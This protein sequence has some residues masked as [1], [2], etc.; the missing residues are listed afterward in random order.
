MRR[1]GEASLGNAGQSGSGV[2]KTSRMV[3]VAIALGVACAFYVGLVLLPR[4]SSVSAPQKVCS[5]WDPICKADAHQGVIAWLALLI[6][7]AAGWL[8][9]LS[10]RADRRAQEAEAAATAEAER[11]RQEANEA[12]ARRRQAAQEAEAEHYRALLGEMLYEDVH[13]LR[14]LSEE[15][16]WKPTDLS[17][18]Y[19]SCKLRGWPDLQFRYTERLLEVPYVSHL[20][21]DLPAA[22]GFLDHTLR[23]AT[24][25]EA[26]AHSLDDPGVAA[27]FAWLTEYLLRI[28]VYASYYGMNRTKTTAREVIEAARLDPSLMTPRSRGLGSV[29]EDL[30]DAVRLVKNDEVDQHGDM[31]DGRKR[32]TDVFWFYP[33]GDKGELYRS[34]RKLPDPPDRPSLTATAS[35]PAP[36][37][38]A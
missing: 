38:A 17:H 23:N 35:D 13:N 19:N 33:S 16:E 8:A 34:F 5:R 6:A 20:E 12:E 28:L 9:Y 32:E 22:V 31:P 27:H 37:A 29:E 15:V 25:I 11:R 3:V 24:W 7:I 21:R 2:A 14:H 1:I 18:E 30:R 10:F 36:F 26:H 4:T